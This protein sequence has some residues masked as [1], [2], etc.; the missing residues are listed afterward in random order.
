VRLFGHPVHP[1][2][3]HFPIVF[4]SCAL[5]ADVAGVA[6]HAPHAAELASAT[7]ALGGASGLLA[8]IAGILDF[9][10]LAKDSPARDPAVAHLMAMCGAWLIFLM[11]LALHGY[12][13][14][15]VVSIVALITTLVGFVTMAIGGWLG[16]KLVYEFGVGRKSAD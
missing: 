11:A 5:A 10:G 2:L 8:M 9:V 16:G 4:W 6:A 12:P 3:V 7:L 13:P 14:A 15:P 1:M